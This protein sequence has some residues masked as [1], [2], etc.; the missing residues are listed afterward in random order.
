MKKSKTLN[1]D[2]IRLYCILH[3]ITDNIMEIPWCGNCKKALHCPE[4]FKT[5][6]YCMHTRDKNGK[7]ILLAN[8]FT[9]KRPAFQSNFYN[10]NGCD[11]CKPKIIGKRND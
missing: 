3:N 4:F 9:M 1:L 2:K 8:T 7:R 10:F 5:A 6:F 11:N